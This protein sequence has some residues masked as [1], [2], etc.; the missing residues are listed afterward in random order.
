MAS[1]G[2]VTKQKDGS[3]KGE[4]RTLTINAPI[5]LRLNLAKSS[6]RQLSDNGRT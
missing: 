2:F 4:L 5:E 1:I 3:Y 6:P